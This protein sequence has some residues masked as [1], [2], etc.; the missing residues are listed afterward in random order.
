MC[1]NTTPYQS[2]HFIF[3]KEILFYISLVCYLHILF[4]FNKKKFFVYF[5]LL[6][7]LI[8]YNTERTTREEVTLF[9]GN[10]K[11]SGKM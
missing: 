9:F 4:D 10:S 3:L 2:N 7:P 1:L 5:V 8:L 6:S 11:D